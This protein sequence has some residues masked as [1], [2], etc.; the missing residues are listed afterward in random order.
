MADLGNSPPAPEIKDIDAPA[1]AEPS[2]HDKI[3]AA[4]DELM[5]K[6]EDADEEKDLHVAD[7]AAAATGKKKKADTEDD[8]EPDLDD[9]EDSELDEETDEDDEPAASADD[10]ESGEDEGEDADDEEDDED[11]ALH[12]A[13]TILHDAQ[14]PASVLKHTPKKKLIAWAAEVAER[15]KGAASASTN[16]QGSDTSADAKGAGKPAQADPAAAW[17]ARRSVI[18]EKLGIDEEAADAFKPLHDENEAMRAE[19]KALRSELEQT[20]AATRARAGQATIDAQMKRLQ[21]AGYPILAKSSKAREKVKDEA[22]T[23]VEGLKARGMALDADKIFDKAVKVLG[24][25]K[26]RDL[27]QL[28]RNGTN[29]VS[30]LG[31]GLTE[32]SSSE[33]AYWMKAVDHAVNGRTELI[34]RMRPPPSLSREPIRR[35]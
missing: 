22:I 10:E 27:A 14:V 31:G 2:M 15:A 6:E 23:I 29:T 3:S 19:V 35:R 1:A 11:I 21:D 24:A 16:G 30:D 4:I 5:P 26:R 32:E 20:N 34:K 17:A 7:V 33:D 25:P 28:R 18:A 13:Y 12:R 9:E 8:D